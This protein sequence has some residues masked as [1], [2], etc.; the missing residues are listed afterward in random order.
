MHPLRGASWH[1]GL[2]FS[3]GPPLTVDQAHSRAAAPLPSAH[4][5]RP[6][7]LL[8]CSGS[9]CLSVPELGRGQ[10]PGGKG[11]A[12]RGGLLGDLKVQ[13]GG[14]AT[15]GWLPQKCPVAA[16]GHVPGS[17]ERGAASPGWP[18]WPGRA[19]CSWVHLSSVAETRTHTSTF[20]LSLSKRPCPRPFPV[21]L[22]TLPK[23]RVPWALPQPRAGLGRALCP[24][25]DTDGAPSGLASRGPDKPA[26]PGSSARPLAP[27][28]SPERER[29]GP[30]QTEP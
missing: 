27:V 14:H 11:L 1:R 7:L 10:R 18:H 23:H 17:V 26:A 5:G 16:E 13:R 15:P 2:G 24:Y 6:V 21:S 20:C 28:P 4:A 22:N 25:L 8:P 3:P 29:P 9:G 19:G 30:G 12:G